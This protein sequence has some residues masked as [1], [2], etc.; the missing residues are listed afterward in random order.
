MSRSSVSELSFAAAK[1]LAFIVAI[2]I[3][4]DSITKYTENSSTKHNRHIYKKTKLVIYQWNI[5]KFV[6]SWKLQ[7]RQL[8]GCN[9]WA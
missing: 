3:F 6:Y 4:F 5:F 7:G 1:W 2:N 8:K 9:G